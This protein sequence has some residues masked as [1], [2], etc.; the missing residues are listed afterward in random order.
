MRCRPDGAAAA[1]GVGGG[2]AAASS[3]VLRPVGRGLHS[4]TFQLNLSA[5][6][7][8]GRAHRGCLARVKGVLVGVQ[9]V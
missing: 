4:S 5:L 2:G 8:I 1:L 9:G 7:G 6:N 3:T